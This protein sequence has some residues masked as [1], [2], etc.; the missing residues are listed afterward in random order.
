MSPFPNKNHIVGQPGINGVK[1]DGQTNYLYFTTT[2]Q[3]LFMRV[4][5][6][7]TTLDPAGAPELIA[8]GR[9]WDDFALDAQAGVAYV[10][11]HRQNTIERIPLDPHSGQAKQIMAGDPFDTRLVGPS[12]VRWGRGE[13][14]VGCVAYVTTDGGVTAS[15][16]DGSVR[17]AQVLRAEF[18]NHG[19]AS[20][21]TRAPTAYRIAQNNR[22]QRGGQLEWPS[23]S[24]CSAHRA[25]GGALN[26][27]CPEWRSSR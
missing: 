11:T 13:N 3:D 9:M 15:P 21:E 22:R 27:H 2:A 4:R 10:T 7:P 14:D 17:P 25:I 16:P 1:F 8:S 23:S 5:V 24:A 6:D 12:A 26:G 18:C 20:L 19:A